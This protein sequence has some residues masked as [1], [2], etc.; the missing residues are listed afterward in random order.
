[1]QPSIDIVYKILKVWAKQ[2]TPKS[3]SDLSDA[4]QIKTGEWHKP[5]GSWD[6][7]LGQLNNVLANAGAP[8]IS[9]LVILKIANEPG[10][11]FW[12]CAPNVPERPKDTIARLSEWKKILDDIFAYKWPESIPSEPNNLVHRSVNICTR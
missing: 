9:A 12:G 8:A 2:E 4:Y 7:P 6:R 10:G 11:N 5:H 3:Y 1:M